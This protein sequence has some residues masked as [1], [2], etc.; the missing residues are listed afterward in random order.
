MNSKQKFI[1]NKDNIFN[2]CNSLKSEGILPIN[3]TR[4][5]VETRMECKGNTQN[6]SKWIA[7][8]KDEQENNSSPNLNVSEMFQ[9]FGNQINAKHIEE[10]TTLQSLHKN[11]ISELNK[12]LASANE[13]LN[14]LRNFKQNFNKFLEKTQNETERLTTNLETSRNETEKLKMLNGCIQKEVELLKVQ[15]E[16]NKTL[17]EAGQKQYL[18]F[19]QEHISVLN[20]LK[21]IHDNEI[22]IE[23]MRSRTTQIKLEK[24]E[25]KFTN[26]FAKLAQK[27]EVIESLNKLIA[28]NNAVNEIE[29]LISKNASISNETHKRAEESLKALTIAINQ[30]TQESKSLVIKFDINQ[31]KTKELSDLSKNQN[32]NLLNMETNTLQI[33]EIAKE[34]KV[35]LS[36]LS[37]E[38]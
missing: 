17:I 9:E 15:I 25:E 18:L 22:E 36:N 16:S 30:N 13:E 24:T 37:I 11:K 26:A 29:Q 7:Q 35:Q 8:W 19:T 1:V 2:L 21:Q 3:I 12:E 31:N 4:V 23:R 6:V 14:E 38:E 5:M 28:A 20:N 10:T 32:V 33:Y 27:S 34:L